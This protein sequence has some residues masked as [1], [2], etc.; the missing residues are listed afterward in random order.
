LPSHT[1]SGGE[2]AMSRLPKPNDATGD[3]GSPKLEPWVGHQV[4]SGR[5][6]IDGVI[7]D[8]RWPR[9]D[10]RWFRTAQER[11]KGAADHRK[12]R[13]P[14]PRT[15]FAFVGGSKGKNLFWARPV[16]RSEVRGRF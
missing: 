10:A 5:A 9:F 16:P 7:A 15:F 11:R 2:C 13:C 14:R 4:F 12:P 3:F 8:T 6:F 1:E